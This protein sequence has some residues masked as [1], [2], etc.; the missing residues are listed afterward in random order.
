MADFSKYNSMFNAEELKAQIKDIEENGGTGDYPEV[1][2][3]TYPVQIAK[4]ELTETKKEP[5]RPM[6]SVW[7]KILDG[8][9]KDQLIFMNQVCEKP[10]QL[11][12]ANEFLKSLESSIP[13]E[14]DGFVRYA[15]VIMDIAEDIE[16]HK[17]TYDLEYGVTKK[18]YNT[19]KIVEVYEG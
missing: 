12:T 9:Y 19:F 13:V 11:H 8:E 15:N 3:G 16:E 2:H 1:P 10:F 7:F 18:G 5:K 6:L 4:L 17:V 14:F